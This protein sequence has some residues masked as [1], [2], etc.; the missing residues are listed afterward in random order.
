[1]LGI[2][3]FVKDMFIYLLIIVIIIL[4]RIYILTTA[5]VIGDS[6][7]PGLINGNLLIVDQISH[8]Y[9]DLDRFQIIVFKHEN[10]QY[11]VKRIIGLP[12]EHIAYIDNKLYVNDKL[13]KEEFEKNGEIEG[14][15]LADIRY[16]I[17]PDDMYLVIGDNRNNSLDSRTIG[18]I[19]EN[20]IIGKPLLVIWP[21]PDLKITK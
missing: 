13:I 12:G 15:T 17:I 3:E 10:R 14:F 18:L 20:I 9:K 8:K 2:I 4:L 6:M 7:E 19:N 1:M 21:I 11:L 16:D 5:Q